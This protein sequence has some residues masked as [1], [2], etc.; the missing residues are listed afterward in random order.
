MDCA[1]YTVQEQEVG[2]GPTVV[3]DAL[4]VLLFKS[5]GGPSSCMPVWLDRSCVTRCIPLAVYGRPIY[6]C[7]WE[8]N[9]TIFIC[10]AFG[11]R[12]GTKGAVQ[13]GQMVPLMHRGGVG[14]P[15]P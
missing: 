10:F 9:L 5:L 7:S 8:E 14:L 4:R 1:P 13:Q 3:V 11:L 12:S 15:R 2:S 6:L